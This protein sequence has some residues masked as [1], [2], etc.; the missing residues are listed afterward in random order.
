MSNCRR[1]FR[2]DQQFEVAICQKWHRGC[3]DAKAA[4]KHEHNRRQRQYNQALA[5]QQIAEMLEEKILPPQ[6]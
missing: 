5:R 2:P 1:W 6:I 3:S 4:F